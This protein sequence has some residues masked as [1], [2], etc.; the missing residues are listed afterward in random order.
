MALIHSVARS[1][2]RTGEWGKTKKSLQGNAKRPS[3]VEVRVQMGGNIPCVALI[4]VLLIVRLFPFVDLY[5]PA[6]DIGVVDSGSHGARPR[7][8]DRGM[9]REKDMPSGSEST[10]YCRF[11][12]KRR[13]KDIPC[14]ILIC[15]MKIVFQCSTRQNRSRVRDILPTTDHTLHFHLTLFISCLIPFLFHVMS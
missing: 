5:A 4:S 12:E 8:S 1:R 14:S 10:K 15:N 3:I 13:A 11:G 9:G 2:C 6:V 7:N